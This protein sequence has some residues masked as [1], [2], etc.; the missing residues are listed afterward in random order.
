[1]GMKTRMLPS[2]VACA[3]AFPVLGAADVE[4]R[5]MPEPP[6]TAGS[7]L[8]RQFSG[9]IAAIDPGTKTLTLDNAPKD[10]GTV[11]IGTRTVITRGDKPATWEQLAVGMR[12]DGTFIGEFEIVAE[13][14]NIRN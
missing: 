8:V 14:L 6:A 9:K 4:L 3:L 11:R 12:V 13:T 1:M 5:P 7:V 10:S 2:M